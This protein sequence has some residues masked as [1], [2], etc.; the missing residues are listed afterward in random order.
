MYW[1]VFHSFFILVLTTG[2]TIDSV[3]SSMYIKNASDSIC[4]SGPRK[5]IDPSITLNLT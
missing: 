5:F 4:K 1:N 2:G 3:S